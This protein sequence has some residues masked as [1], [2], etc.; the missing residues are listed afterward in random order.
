M[1]KINDISILTKSAR[2]HCLILFTL[3][4]S[5]WQPFILFNKPLLKKGCIK[6][7]TVEISFNGLRELTTFG[8]HIYS[9]WLRFLTV[10]SKSTKAPPPSCVCD[11][12][13]LFTLD[14]KMLSFQDY[15]RIEGGRKFHWIDILA[16]KQSSLV[17]ISTVKGWALEDERSGRKVIARDQQLFLH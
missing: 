4:I 9:T 7:F 2:F 12:K 14:I 5:F 3:N 13:G 17:L 15:G 6:I 1:W 16:K 10:I 11:R 8:H